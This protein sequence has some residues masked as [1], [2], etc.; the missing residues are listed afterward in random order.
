MR[1]AREVR[2][3]RRRNR[4]GRMEGTEPADGARSRARFR[5]R[6]AVGQQ[7]SSKR[8]NGKPRSRPSARCSF[9]A[10]RW[11]AA[12][13][14]HARARRPRQSSRMV[15]V[16]IR[17]GR[18]GLRSRRS[19][20]TKIRT[21]PDHS[22]ASIASSS[23]CTATISISP[24]FLFRRIRLRHDRA[25][26]IRAW[27]LPSGAPRR[28]APAGSRRT[29]RL[30]RTRPVLSG[31]GR[32]AQRL[33]STA[34]STGRS[35]AVSCTRMPPTTF[36]NTS[37]S[38]TADAAVA[39]QHREQHRQTVL[40]EPERDAPRIARAATDRPAPALRPAAAACLRA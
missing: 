13:R 17:C 16:R 14:S 1:R 8:C 31:S 37:W 19:N 4:S 28:S 29:A 5:F 7:Y 30:R 15:A 22:I 18:A 34:S 6:F 20:A 9:S 25:A 39:M 12:S 11:A 24:I 27:P 23:R 3:A 35:A 10:T 32:V 40:L 36:T 21:V 26:G 38:Y 33:D 2:R